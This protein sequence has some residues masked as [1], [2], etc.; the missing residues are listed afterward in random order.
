MVLVCMAAGWYFFRGPGAAVLRNLTAREPAAAVAANGKDPP[1]PPAAAPVERP[2]AEAAPPPKA[3]AK[4]KMEQPPAPPP[5]RPR[6]EQSLPKPLE[7]PQPPPRP[8]EQL[9]GLT[10][11]KDILPIFQAKCVNCHNE[12]KKRGGLDV[13]SLA[14]L[15]KGGESGPGV[16]AGALDRSTLW[17]AVNTNQM[18]PTPNKLNPAEKK[19]LQDWILQGAR[20]GVPAARP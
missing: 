9:A 1:A 17:G 3:P 2:K 8:P 14:A 19:L 16:V 12:D 4:P 20:G 11:E 6:E 18:P 5:D 10:F 7:Q 15:R 13:T